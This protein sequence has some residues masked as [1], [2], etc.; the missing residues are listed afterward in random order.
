MKLKDKV[1]IVTGATKGIG[2]AC[3]QQMAA[4]GAKAVLAARGEELGEKV[5]R[6]IVEAGCEAVFVKCDVSKKADV[7]HLVD[8][9][10]EQYGG[11]DVVV[12]NAGVNHSANFF[13]TTEE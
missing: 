12:N 1:A 7:D 10:V 3:A 9:A 8:V 5:T 6:E 2:L 11:I 13:D 4:E